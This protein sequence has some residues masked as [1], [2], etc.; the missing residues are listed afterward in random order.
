MT[1]TP[2]ILEASQQLC[3]LMQ[4]VDGT[5]PHNTAKSQ[6]SFNLPRPLPSLPYPLLLFLHVAGRRDDRDL[7][8]VP[9]PGPGGG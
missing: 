2:K 6:S 5:V 1:N 4:E 8:C 9:I 3:G 7:T